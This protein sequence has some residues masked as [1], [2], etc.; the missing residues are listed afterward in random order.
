MKRRRSR[1]YALQI[2]FQLELTD[3][4][5]SDDMLSDFWEGNDEDDE[6]KE[7]TYKTVMTA[8]KNIDKIDE[9]IQKAAQHWSLKRMAA[10]DRNI[11]RVATCELMFRTDIP[12]SVAI[13][14]ALEIAKKYSTE[15][16]APFINGILDR[17]A[18]ELSSSSNRKEK[19]H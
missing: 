7:F 12:P 16:S 11:L 10:I 13:N 14:E 19:S 4:Q 18:R 8:R 9:A 3:N 6:V 15:E 2:M 5:L 17:I 1:E